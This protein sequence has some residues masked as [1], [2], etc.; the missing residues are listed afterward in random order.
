MVPTDILRELLVLVHREPYKRGTTYNM[1]LGNKAPEARI[2]R[3]V[4]I[5]THHKVVVH[6]K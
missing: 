2:G 1:V 3:V 4:A 6:L 5:V